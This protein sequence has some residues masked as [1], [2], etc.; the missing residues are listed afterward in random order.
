MAS[1]VLSGS[2]NVTYTNNTGQNVRVVINYMATPTNMSWAGVSVTATNV[3]AIGRN[4]AF[5]NAVSNTTTT[6]NYSLT[7]NNMAL[8]DGTSAVES[9]S[10]TLPIEIMLSTGQTFSTTCAA[11]NIVIIP[12]AG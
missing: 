11:Y 12:E 5:S 3:R 2:S 8:I 7:A 6:G 10:T 9:A 1:T 4:L